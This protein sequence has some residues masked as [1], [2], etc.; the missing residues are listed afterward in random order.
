M[1]NQECIVTLLDEDGYRSAY[2]GTTVAA[3]LA[4]ILVNSP[5]GY[6]YTAQLYI[7]SSLLEGATIKILIMYGIK[8]LLK[9]R[10]STVWP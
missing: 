8:T 10:Q 9:V 4:V 7:I 3:A 1:Y 2:P 5:K 6:Q